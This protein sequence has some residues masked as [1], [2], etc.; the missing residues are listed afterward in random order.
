M[1]EEVVR[2]VVVFYWRGFFIKSLF[3]DNKR[4]N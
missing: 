3:K 1:L 4:D 2:K